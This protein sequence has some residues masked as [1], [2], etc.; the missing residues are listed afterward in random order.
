MKSTEI[1]HVKVLENT[2]L[3]LEI[4]HAASYLKIVEE[5]GFNATEEYIHGGLFYISHQTNPN[6]IALSN[7]ST[8]T[9]R[10]V[11]PGTFLSADDFEDLTSQLKEAG[12]RLSKVKEKYQYEK[13]SEI[14]ILMI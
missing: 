13:K 7:L 1:K 8:H 9:N 4:K 12:A 5:L 2:I 3:I 6:C 11:E 10:T 14:Q